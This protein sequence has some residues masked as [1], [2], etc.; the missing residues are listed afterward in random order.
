MSAP[1]RRY[2]QPGPLTGSALR[3][4]CAELVEEVRGAA[5]DDDAV[6]AVVAAM[7]HLQA[8]QLTAEERRGLAAVF[9]YELG[10]DEGALEAENIRRLLIRHG[11][12][13]SDGLGV[14]R[15]TVAMV[16]DFIVSRG[17]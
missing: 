1:L 17:R 10:V 7:S 4:R 13:E 12:R 16:E 14:V 5:T 6:D 9:G 2:V 3:A 11:V 8:R 15:S